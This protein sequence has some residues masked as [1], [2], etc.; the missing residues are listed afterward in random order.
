MK[1]YKQL[2]IQ[3]FTAYC[4][5]YWRMKTSASCRHTMAY[6]KGLSSKLF[7]SLGSESIHSHLSKLGVDLSWSKMKPVEDKKRFSKLKSVWLI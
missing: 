2:N 3:K 4:T 5:T 7:Y 6:R 1:L